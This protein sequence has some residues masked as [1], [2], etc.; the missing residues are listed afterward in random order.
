MKCDL[1]RRLSIFHGT[2]GTKFGI[3]L[4]TQPQL[5]ISSAI[6]SGV[7]ARGTGGILR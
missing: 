6:A 5:L 3:T 4:P 2:F 7:L 1:K